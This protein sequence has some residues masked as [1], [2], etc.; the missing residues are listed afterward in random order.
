MGNLYLFNGICANTIW[1]ICIYLMEFVQILCGKFVV[2]SWNLCKYYVISCTL[3]KYYVG[4]LYLFDGNCQNSMLEI[5]IYLM[6]I[7]QILYGKLVFI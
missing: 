5:C 3:C 7:V 2:I 4:N 6:E 1:Q